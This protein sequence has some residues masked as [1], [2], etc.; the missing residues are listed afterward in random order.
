[1]R[2]SIREKSASSSRIIRR[3]SGFTLIELLIAIL[4]L[5]II[6]AI[7]FSIYRVYID[8][9][10]VTIA[11]SVLTD[12]QKNLE[13][14][15]VDNKKYP[16]SIDFTSCIDENSRS[17]F[18]T[19]FCDQMKNDLSSIDGY[20]ANAATSYSLTARAKD[21]KNTLMTLTPQNITIQGQ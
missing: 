7:A 19:T 4:I 5:A 1:M 3:S 15:L 12:A 11:Q 8:K 20:S 14:Y 13:V 21:T 6:V 9:A 17:V 16:T 18:D 10:K 2:K